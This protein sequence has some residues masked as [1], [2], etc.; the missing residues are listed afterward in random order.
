M[1]KRMIF[2]GAAAV[3]AAVPAALG[4][5]GNTSFG[6][7]V[8]VQVPARAAIVDDH[9]R[10][11]TAVGTISST[12]AT[13]EPGDDHGSQPT[14]PTSRHESEPGDDHDGDRTVVTTEAGDDHG[15]RTPGGATESGDDRGTTTIEPGDH[16]GDIAPDQSVTGGNQ[17]FRGK[18]GVT[19]RS[20]ESDSAP[21]DNGGQSSDSGHGG[22]D[23]GAGHS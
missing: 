2:I 12:T 20:A 18:Q 22:K 11:R 17:P 10:D 1:M 6:E 9:G 23:D 3:F 5:L 7:S 21:A 4:L 13:V 19:S 15:G 8:P 14:G 16:R